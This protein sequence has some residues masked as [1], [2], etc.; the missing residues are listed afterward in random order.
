MSGEYGKDS[1]KIKFDSDNDLLLNKLLKL[2]IKTTTIRII[3]Q[4]DTL[5]FI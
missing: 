5:E 2:H 1:M 4:K 3:F